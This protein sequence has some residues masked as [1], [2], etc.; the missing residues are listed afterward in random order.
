ME[1]MNR[2]PRF[3]LWLLLLALL[4]FL[5]LPV[6]VLARELREDKVVFGG[7]YT[8]ESGQV[9]DGSLVVLVGV[10][11]LQSGAVVTRDVILVGGTLRSSGQ[12]DGDLV[13]VG[14]LIS[15]EKSALVGGDVVAVGASLE[16]QPG[17]RIQ[18]E[19]VSGLNGPLTFNFPGQLDAPRVEFGLTPLV[20]F[21]WYFFRAFLWAALAVLLLLFIPRPV[22]RVAQAV[23]SQPVVSGALGLLT[24]I[25]APLVLILLMVTII[26]IP[27]SALGFLLLAALWAYGLVA[28]GLEVGR[29]LALSF[30]L[31]LAPAAAAGVGT[32]GLILVLNGLRE[33]VPCVGW[34]FPF[35]AGCFGLGAVILTR[36]G[37]QDYLSQGNTPP[38]RP[39]PPA[40]G[41]PGRLAADL[42]EESAAGLPEQAGS[43]TT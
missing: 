29:R 33:L 30:K 31:D 3:W 9:L 19:V 1:Q 40:G 5:A 20:N 21:I 18:G 15:L 36:L 22:E 8:L 23:V 37:S 39:V 13:G 38:T 16:R 6:P 11:E 12:V 34:V 41:L 17:A 27:V 10:A 43:P 2:L 32:L 26:L 28:L 25:A 24:I 14:G 7:S 4:A 35:L 42:D